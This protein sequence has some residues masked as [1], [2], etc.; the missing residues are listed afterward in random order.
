MAEKVVDLPKKQRRT[1][2]RTPW[3][4]AWY[5]FMRYVVIWT[6]RDVLRRSVEPFPW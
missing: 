5:L 4:F 2:L 6:L 3:R 1:V